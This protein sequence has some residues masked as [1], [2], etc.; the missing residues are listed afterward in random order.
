MGTT[1]DCDLHCMPPTATEH[2][3]HCS[4]N[5]CHGKPLPAAEYPLYFGGQLTPDG[6]PVAMDVVSPYPVLIE[7]EGP[8]GDWRR[9]G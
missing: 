3:T 4:C 2:E 9:A 7:I 6:W 5:R 1:P 8:W